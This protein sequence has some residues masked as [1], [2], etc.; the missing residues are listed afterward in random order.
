MKTELTHPNMKCYISG[1]KFKM[2][3]PQVKNFNSTQKFW[4]L[5]PSVH[6]NQPVLFLVTS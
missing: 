4:Q 5:F 1:E 2:N 6:Q 3:S